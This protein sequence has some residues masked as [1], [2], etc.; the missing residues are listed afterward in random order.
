MRLRPCWGGA[1]NALRLTRRVCELQELKESLNI[2]LTDC[3]EP[4]VVDLMVLVFGGKEVCW[5]RGV[6]RLAKCQRG[7]NNEC[8]RS[9]GFLRGWNSVDHGG[10]PPDFSA[11]DDHRRFGWIRT[12]S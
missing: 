11:F 3:F 6:Q 4:I 10:N 2:S 8:K 7:V 1:Q 12:V 9:D 5:G